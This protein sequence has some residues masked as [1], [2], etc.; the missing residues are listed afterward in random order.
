MMYKPFFFNQIDMMAAAKNL[1]DFER[2]HK[3]EPKRAKVA[4]NPLR[5]QH[6]GELGQVFEKDELA[7]AVKAMEETGARFVPRAGTDVCVGSTLPKGDGVF[8]AFSGSTGFFLATLNFDRNGVPVV[9]GTFDHSVTP[10]WLLDLVGTELE[11]EARRLTYRMA[12][13]PLNPDKRESQ[14][15]DMFYRYEVHSLDAK[16]RFLGLL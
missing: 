8:A 9:E 2:E 16:A 5:K 11:D 1:S 3:D 13:L 7:A 10:G 12:T 6:D 15:I 4:A 14:E